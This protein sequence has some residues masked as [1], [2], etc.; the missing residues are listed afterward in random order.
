[1][2]QP[3]TR[4]AIVG[5]GVAGLVTATLL[6]RRGIDVRIFEQTPQLG[7]IGAGIQL[8]PNGVRVLHRLGLQAALARTGV[9]AQ[10]IETRRWADGTR[11]A[12]VRHGVA[13][14]ELFGAPY[15]LIHRAD[16]QRCLLSVLP[17]HVM[18]LGKGCTRV[19]EGPDE[20]AL[21]FAD[22]TTTTADV[23]IGADGVHSA[24]RAAVVQDE[25]RFSGYA[26]HR[27][28]VPAAAVPSFATDPRVLFWLGPRRHVTYYP[29]RG[30]D[31]VHFSAVGASN[32]AR[33]GSF[34]S[35]D[36]MNE[37][38][39]GFADWHEEVRRVVTAA[40]SVTRWGVFDRDLADRY[41]T[42]RIALLGDAAHPTLP[43]LSQGANQALED[44]VTLAR[45]LWEADPARLAPALHRYQSLRRPR[46]A[47]VHRRAR[48]LARTF[49]LPDGQEQT[50]RDR[51]MRDRQEPEHL[52]W[53]YG[54][55]A[56]AATTP[57]PGPASPVPA[58]VPAAHPIHRL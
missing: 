47:E 58:P 21:H 2:R 34:S 53:L 38:A 6:R 41:V 5:G 43:Y 33:T 57:T 54:F 49:H 1:M 42:G 29:V 50:D 37:L 39:T 48:D 45:C 12:R 24:V 25:P 46:T 35:P 3:R 4:V 40:G 13:C 11:I 18:E 7:A 52:S 14:T 32:D 31:I 28:L 15:Y 51:E 19:V 16:L 26:V 56:D 10:A 9:R 36:E 22:G 27:G 55:D 44:A 17:E 20:V 23:V 30:G 8:S